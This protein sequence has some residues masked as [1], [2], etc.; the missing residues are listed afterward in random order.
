V[1]KKG[2][3]KKERKKEIKRERKGTKEITF[4]LHDNIFTK[5]NL[6]F[7]ISTGGRAIAQAISRCLPTAAALVQTRV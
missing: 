2:R 1:G 7:K 6:R 5:S 3:R 4:T